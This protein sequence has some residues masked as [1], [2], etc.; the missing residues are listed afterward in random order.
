MA[1]VDWH[2]ILGLWIKDASRE[3]I[4]A[5]HKLAEKLHDLKRTMEAIKISAGKQGKRSLGDPEKQKEVR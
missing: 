1:F 4:K 3:D 2:E 5:Y